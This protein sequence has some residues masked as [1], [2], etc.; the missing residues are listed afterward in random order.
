MGELYHYGRRGM[1]W[2][3]RLYQNKDGSLTALGRLRYRKNQKSTDKK[4]KAALEKARKAKSAK[5]QEELSVE[6]QRKKLLLPIYY[7][8]YTMMPL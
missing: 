5:K 6:E 7:Q 2:G 4:R 8:P 1:K 3:Q